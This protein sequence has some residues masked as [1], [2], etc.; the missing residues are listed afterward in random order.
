MRKNILN[1]IFSLGFNLFLLIFLFLGIQNSKG[2]KRINL[3][4]YETIELPI[5]FIIGTSFIAGS[6]SGVII[7]LLGGSKE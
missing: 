5:S 2:S 4:Q 6:L 7:S 3:I 1:I